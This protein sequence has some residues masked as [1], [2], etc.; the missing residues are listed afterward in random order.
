MAIVP[1]VLLAIAAFVIITTGI[2]VRV[3][4]GRKKNN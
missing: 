2:I 3:R 4:S 1:L